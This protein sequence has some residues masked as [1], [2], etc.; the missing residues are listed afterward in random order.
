M[1]GAGAAFKKKK[2]PEHYPVARAKACYVGAIV[3]VFIAETRYAGCDVVYDFVGDYVLLL[4]FFHAE[5]G[6][7]DGHVTGVQTCALPIS[8]S[9]AMFF[10][11][12]PIPVKEAMAMMGMIEPEFRLPMC[13]MTEPNRQRLKAVLAQHGLLK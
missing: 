12:N 8:L 9:R 1:P 7:R 13:P 6:I 2:S 5:D 10:E 11:T 4:F 3:A